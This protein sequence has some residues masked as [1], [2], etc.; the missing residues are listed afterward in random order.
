MKYDG[1]NSTD[2]VKD[3]LIILKKDAIKKKKKT[4]ANLNFTFNFN[5]F[6]SLV[7]TSFA[8]TTAA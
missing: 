3:Y 8:L 7:C 1:F 4:P 6:H 5:E 2:Y